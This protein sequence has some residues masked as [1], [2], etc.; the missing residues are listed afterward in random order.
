MGWRGV[1][2]V[3]RGRENRRDRFGQ[4]KLNRPNIGV[5][6]RQRF[7][8]ER[9]RS[10]LQC[11]LGNSTDTVRKSSLLLRKKSDSGNHVEPSP[12]KKIGV[13]V[14][15]TNCLR[16]LLSEPISPIYHS[17]CWPECCWSH[18]CQFTV[19]VACC[20]QVLPPLRRALAVLPGSQSGTMARCIPRCLSQIRASSPE[21]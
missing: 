7:S 12:T 17:C 13:R 6:I 5:K 3:W 10:I 8:T 15:H 21:V 14:R 19:P 16:S 1:F 4:S 20:G 2:G 9:V 11:A 18:A